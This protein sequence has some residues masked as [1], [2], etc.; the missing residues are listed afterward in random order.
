MPIPTPFHDRTAALCTSYKWADWAGYCAVS[1]YNLPNEGEYYS[2]RHAAG[3]ID[4]SPLLKYEVSGPDAVAFLS[5]IMAKNIDNIPIGRAAYCCWCDDFGKIIDDGTVFRLDTDRLRVHTAEPMLAWFGQFRRGLD[6]IIEDISADIAAVAIQGPTSREILKQISDIDLDALV[7][8]GVTSA[9]VDNLPV[10][11][12][13][14]G[15]TGDLGY[16]LW[17]P[18]SDALPL[19]DALMSAG[20]PYLLQP[21]G[22][23]VLD[24][25]RIEAGLILNGVEFHNAAHCL[26][27]SQKSTPYELGLGWTVD[28]DRE[29]FCGQ[30]A[31]KAEQAAGQQ[32]ALVGLELDWDEQEA[33]YAKHGLPVQVHPGAWRSG[34]P[35]YDNRGSRQIGKATS[36]AWS[37][38]IKKNLALASVETPYARTGKTLKIEY[39]V[40][41]QRETVNAVIV[42]MPFYNPENK[43]R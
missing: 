35:V 15:Y 17:V 29:P 13:R 19:W 7:Y 20:K 32:L 42:K 21:F 2:L 39:T 12:S 38:L 40:E 22:L 14:T 11:I 31:L 6:V 36:G 18:N 34:V 24:I 28:L 27:E 41:Y 10:L 3:I 16:E 8:Y 23:D 1:S 33:L 30:Q 37:P 4:I 26:I 9:Q 5:R 25:A 43:R